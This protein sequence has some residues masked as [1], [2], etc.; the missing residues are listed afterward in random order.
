MTEIDH[1]LEDGKPHVP[2][3]VHPSCMAFQDHGGSMCC[4]ALREQSEHSEQRE[5]YK[6]RSVVVAD[7][8]SM[9]N[10]IKHS[11]HIISEEV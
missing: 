3:C 8:K 1:G 7:P 11:L 4:R 10:M 9:V 5:W 2:Q 6:L